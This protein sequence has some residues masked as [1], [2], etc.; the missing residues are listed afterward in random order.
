MSRWLLQPK[1]RPRIEPY[2]DW[3]TQST[4][5]TKL[6]DLPLHSPITAGTFTIS[7]KTFNISSTDITLKELMDQINETSNGVDGVN[8]EGDSTGITISYDDSIDK[9]VIKFRCEQR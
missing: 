2:K 3:V 6:S 4:L 7:G 9:M 1:F 8:P 5:T